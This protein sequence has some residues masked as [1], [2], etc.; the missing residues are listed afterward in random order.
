MACASGGFSL[1]ELIVVVAVLG[2]LS[3]VFLPMTRDAD[4]EAL[5][6]ANEL[7]SWLDTVQRRS[8]R[9]VAQP[10]TVTF[11]LTTSNSAIATGDQLASVVPSNCAIGAVRVP[12]IQFSP[13][14]FQGRR[15]GSATLVYTPRGTV[16]ASDD[17]VL[18]LQPQGST[19]LRCVRVSGVLGLISLG[20]ATLTSPT[21]TATTCADASYSAVFP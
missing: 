20:S 18:S 10:C 11:D 4:G 8:Q 21:D 3:A 9:L 12:A 16:T 15:S 14:R 17:T 5:A 2:V 19:V 1:L 13:G 6:V 7:A